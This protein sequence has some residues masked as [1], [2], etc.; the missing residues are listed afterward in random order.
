VFN[1]QRDVSTFEL[2]QK[3]LF[4]QG[5]SVSKRDP[6]DR[7]LLTAWLNFAGGA[8]GY[9]ELVDTDGNGT[10]DMQFHTAVENAEA[11]RLNPAATPA[12]LDQERAIINRINDTI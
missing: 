9:A 10:K 2:A 5:A 3:L 7:D 11:V 1:E 12:Q 4:A 6:L 8:V